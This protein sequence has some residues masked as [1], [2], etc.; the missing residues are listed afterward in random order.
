[1]R[2]RTIEKSEVLVYE[3]SDNFFRDDGINE[4]QKS[5]MNALGENIKVFVIDL[6]EV[7]H[8]NSIGLAVLIRAY[9]STKK[10]GAEMILTSLNL[11]VKEMLSITRID[12]LFKIYDTS[13][14]AVLISTT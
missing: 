14:E 7:D 2:F 12:S 9:T 11:K 13:E 6:G 5:I 4:F 10:A 3:I 8:I 1:M